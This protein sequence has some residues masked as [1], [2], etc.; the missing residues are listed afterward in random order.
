MC[1]CIGRLQLPL[2][3]HMYRSS[4]TA[5]SPRVAPSS[6]A[7]RTPCSPA[8]PEG[9]ATA[10]RASHVQM[11]T[12]AYAR[13]H[14]YMC[15][16]AHLPMCMCTPVHALHAVQPH[17]TVNTAYTCAYLVRTH[18]RMC[19]HTHTYAGASRRRHTYTCICT[20]T[21]IHTR[22]CVG[23][24]GDIYTYAHAHM[25]T[26]VRPGGKCLPLECEE[27]RRR[28]AF[29]KLPPVP[30]TQ[31]GCP[32]L[33]RKPELRTNHRRPNTLLLLHSRAPS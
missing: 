20:H 9:G 24:G 5:S 17:P 3:V 16:C 22:R 27:R 31:E 33:R 2:H 6:T 23:P 11:C 30:I 7:R 18:I 8:T 25:H 12:P 15:T 26:Q 4:S 10:R 28:A 32:E 1:T 14:T 21:Q 29:Y 13:A 19:T